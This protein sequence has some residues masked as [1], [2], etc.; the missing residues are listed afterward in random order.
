MILLKYFYSSTLKVWICDNIA[1]VIGI[2]VLL[3]LSDDVAVFGALAVGLRPATTGCLSGGVA[4]SRRVAGEDRV[5]TTA[6]RAVDVRQVDILDGGLDGGRA[7]PGER[8]AAEQVPVEVFAEYATDEIQRHWVDAGVD[9]AQAEADDA[10]RVPVVVV[11]V[12]R[13][14]AE[15]KPHHEHVVRQ[16][17]NHEYDDERQHHL[18]HL[19][20]GSDLARLAGLLQLAGH[21]ARGHHQVV[22]HQ[23]V[24]ASDHA[25]RHHVVRE[26]LEH[27]HAPCVTAAQLHRERVTV[28]QGHVRL[29]YR[30][31]GQVRERGRRRGQNHSQYPYGYGRH[32]CERLCRHV[33]SD[34]VHNC[35][36]PDR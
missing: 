13:A 12:T 5:V 20:P 30:H 27:D 16:E 10:E 23:Q 3:S 26:Q 29:G 6:R 2:L 34:G 14:R 21:V 11:I 24:E 7:G 32:Q 36:I 18:G 19:L 31:G 22:G 9:E 28:L 35:A 4:E 17:A 25:Q 8:A 15:V 1:I 33:P